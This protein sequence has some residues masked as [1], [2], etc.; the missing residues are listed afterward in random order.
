[1]TMTPLEL[2]KNDL[3]LFHAAISQQYNQILEEFNF[4][5]QG[6]MPNRHNLGREAAFLVL[7]QAFLIDVDN[8]IE[9]M[10]DNPALFSVYTE[11]EDPAKVSQGMLE[12]SKDTVAAAAEDEDFRQAAITTAQK[13]SPHVTPHHFFAGFPA[14]LS[15]LEDAVAQAQDIISEIISDSEKEPESVPATPVL[16]PG[17][18]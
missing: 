2:I 1:M 8:K 5:K 11:S 12:N 10:E 14:V 4:D 18:N 16:K 7:A 17:M 13:E 6:D 9:A 15:W 3:I